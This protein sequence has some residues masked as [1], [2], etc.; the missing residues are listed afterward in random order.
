MRRTL[1][2]RPRALAALALVAALFGVLLALFAAPE[3]QPA[4]VAAQP[5]AAAPAVADETPPERRAP[6][7]ALGPDPASVAAG[8]F[9]DLPASFARQAADEYRRRARYPGSSQ[10]VWP[11]ELDPIVRDREVTPV[12]AKGRDG[13]EPTLHVKPARLAFEAPEPVVL[14]AWLS[15]DG[16]PVPSVT[17]RGTLLSE[18]LQPLA[19]FD[20]VDDGTSGDAVEG[21]D[22][23]A[24]TLHLPDELTPELSASYLV[25][26]KAITEDDD[27][28]AAATS[29]QYANPHARLTGRFAEEVVDGSLRLSAEVEVWRAGRF[30]IEATLYDAAGTQPIAWAQGAAELAPGVQS[31]TLT[32]F[33]AALRDRGIDGPYLLRYVALSTTTAMPNAKSR[34][35]EN[36]FV[37][38]AHRAT[39]FSADGFDDPELL[40]A[41]D[42]LERDALP[43]GLE[44]NG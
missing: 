17:L 42:R 37:T 30:H 39:A 27:D 41:A 2:S 25:D 7:D 23:R 31:M 38:R 5:A 13:K 44:A 34:V 1:A 15:V 36:A 14:Y 21:D 18:D 40:E 43:H 3:R 19:T 32:F 12:T 33:G 9:A 24:V 11:T 4:A 8:S 22:L 26:V 16:D 35:L 28:R 20:F 6:P 10:P 29:F